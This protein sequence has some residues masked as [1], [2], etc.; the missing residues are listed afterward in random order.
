MSGLTQRVTADNCKLVLLIVG[1]HPG[2]LLL[3]FAS[4]AMAV[5]GITDRAHTRGLQR[6]WNNVLKIGPHTSATDYEVLHSSSR[7]QAWTEAGKS[8]N[9]ST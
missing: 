6:G 5:H 3:Y 9:S 7:Y 4:F 8:L 1:S 2:K